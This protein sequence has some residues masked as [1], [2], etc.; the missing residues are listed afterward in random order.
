MVVVVPHVMPNV[1]CGHE[2]DD[3]RWFD[4]T[5]VVAFLRARRCKP[6][7]TLDG[8]V[9]GVVGRGDGEVMAWDGTE[10]GTVLPCLGNL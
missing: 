7:D 1:Q 6:L 8:G 9:P 3:L 10:Y 4:R 5:S 2:E